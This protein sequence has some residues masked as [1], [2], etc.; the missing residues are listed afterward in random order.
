MSTQEL[1]IDEGLYR[2][3]MVVYTSST[4]VDNAD[5]YGNQNNNI[6]GILFIMIDAKNS[7][8]KNIYLNAFISFTNNCT[9]HPPFD[10]GINFGWLNFVSILSPSRKYKSATFVSFF[11]FFR[12]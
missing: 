3:E 12:F 2:D 1:A 5:G 7:Q 6:P 4:A 10:E 8:G 9:A 11:F